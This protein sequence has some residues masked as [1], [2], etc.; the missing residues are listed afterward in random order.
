MDSS[1]II[2]LVAIGSSAVVTI[3][4]AIIG[5]LTNKE[6]NRAKRSEIAFERRL[7][8][9]RGIIEKSGVLKLLGSSGG[10]ML[11]SGNKTEIKSYE[12]DLKQAID[13]FY[14]VYQ[15]ER[16][17]LPPHISDMVTEYGN[18]SFQYI[19]NEKHTTAN[20]KEWCNKII[21]KEKEI[22]AE[23]QRFIGFL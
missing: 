16:V 21:A 8:A 7:D 20:I 23:M 10:K 13:E 17:Y 1:E 4:V 19:V 14:R 6:N 2:A 3:V 11:S 5:Y 12:L 22:V 15:Q 9:F 18:L